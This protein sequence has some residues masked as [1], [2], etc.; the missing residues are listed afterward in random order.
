MGDFTTAREALYG[1]QGELS[2]PI[3]PNTNTNELLATLDLDHPDQ[4]T[5]EK[6]FVSSENP[7]ADFF[8]FPEE[9]QE[10]FPNKETI[11]PNKE[12]ILPNKEILVEENNLV[13]KSS[14]AESSSFIAETLDS[15]RANVG[16]IDPSSIVNDIPEVS[17]T[18]YDFDSY[19]FSS[20]STSIITNSVAVENLESSESSEPSVAEAIT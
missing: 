1:K 5:P 18:D 7:L 19:D 2:A 6:S 10:V 11:L 20:P 16:L 14:V 17:L 4:K 3:S 9:E 13:S 15:T 12:T 8:F